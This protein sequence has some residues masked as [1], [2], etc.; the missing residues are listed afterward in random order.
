[1]RCGRR[2][3]Y[4][5][6]YPEREGIREQPF[7]SVQ[8]ANVARQFRQPQAVVLRVWIIQPEARA[9]AVA[10]HRPVPVAG[11]RRSRRPWSAQYPGHLE[12]LRHSTVAGAMTVAKLN[13][14]WEAGKP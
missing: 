1:M 6:A 3:F 5:R 14:M 12:L 11:R 8:D 2:G 4:L 9:A 7:R 13:A 10:E